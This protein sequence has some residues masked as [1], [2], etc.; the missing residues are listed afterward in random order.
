LFAYSLAYSLFDLIKVEDEEERSKDN[1]ASC[2]EQSD[3][4]NAI[5]AKATTNA[6]K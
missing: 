4:A 5:E 2:E 6:N 1:S 3:S